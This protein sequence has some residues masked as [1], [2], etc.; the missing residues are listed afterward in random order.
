M[1]ATYRTMEKTK[2]ARPVNFLVGS[3]I[4]DRVNVIERQ[5]VADILRTIASGHASIQRNWL[6]NIVVRVLQAPATATL[7][8][9]PGTVRSLLYSMSPPQFQPQHVNPLEFC[10]I[11]SGH[12]TTVEIKRSADWIFAG[13]PGN[14]FMESTALREAVSQFI[15]FNGVESVG[16]LYPCLKVDQRGVGCL[17]MSEKLPLYTISLSYDAHAMR[18]SQGNQST[19]K[20]ID[21]QYPWEIDVATI[22][23]NNLFDDWWDAVEHFNPRR[24][25]KKVR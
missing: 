19:G 3:I 1:R 7:V 4:P 24:A 5:K 12:A 8:A 22:K 20:K 2:Q 14:D 21:L 17:G 15:A 10:A 9:I 6:P 18:W 13:R 23:E 11:G 25:R 16:G